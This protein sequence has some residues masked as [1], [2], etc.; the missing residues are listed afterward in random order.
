MPLLLPV[1]RAALPLT[2]A[3][4]SIRAAARRVLLGMARQRVAIVFDGLDTFSSRTTIHHGITTAS[5]AK[6]YEL[7]LFADF[8]QHVIDE[9]GASSMTA[10]D[11]TICIT[12]NALSTRHRDD[13]R[14]KERLADAKT[15]FKTCIDRFWDNM[16]IVPPAS[17]VPNASRRTAGNDD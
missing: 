16:A 14:E 15:F 1:G 6:F 11:S 7:S 8:L 5:H 3:G 13:E 10:H 4:I 12:A 17:P 2:E 9:L